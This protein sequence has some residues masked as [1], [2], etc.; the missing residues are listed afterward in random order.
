MAVLATVVSA[1]VELVHKLGGFRPSGLEEMFRALHVAFTQDGPGAPPSR[2]SAEPWRAAADFARLMA[3]RPSHIGVRLLSPRRLPIL[4]VFSDRFERMTAL[5]F[6]EQLAHT[7]VGEQMAG[8]SRAELRRSLHHAAYQFE[9][10][11]QAQ[12]DYFRR[13]A[14]VISALVAFGFVL[15]GNIN[16]WTLY[17]HLAGSSEAT[18][19]TLRF[20][21]GADVEALAQ[22]A[23]ATYHELEALSRALPPEGAA[24]TP[25]DPAV[26]RAAVEAAQGRLVRFNEEVADARAEFATDEAVALPIGWSQYPY[27]AP[28]EPGQPVGALALAQTGD[29]WFWLL[30]MIGTAGLLA[31]GAPFWFDLFRSLAV[32]VTATRGADA[33]AGR[34]PPRAAPEGPAT[35]RDPGRTDPDA[36][37]EAFTLSRGASPAALGEAELGRRVGPSSASVVARNAPEDSIRP[38]RR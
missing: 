36:L 15:V 31:L 24:L 18:Q 14:K 26:L 12:S 2:V 17:T 35:L 5:Q 28:C 25:D 11:G 27:C 32:L 22:E 29:F 9:R 7:D 33:V 34:A 21:D 30:C 16:G 38:L 13:R 10:Y 8:R 37:V 23:D 1:L 3:R 6:V 4:R 20:L 19:A